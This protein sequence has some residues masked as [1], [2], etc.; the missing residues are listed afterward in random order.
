MGVGTLC[1][2]LQ[3]DSHILLILELA[4][5]NSKIVDGVAVLISLDYGRIFFIVC[6][7]PLHSRLIVLNIMGNGT[8]TELGIGTTLAK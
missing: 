7:H 8:Q 3:M 1:Q 6:F 2:T 4:A 5:I